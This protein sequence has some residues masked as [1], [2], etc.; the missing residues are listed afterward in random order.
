M[1]K[2]KIPLLLILGIGL[3]NLGNWIYFIAINIKILDLTG[4]AAAVAGLFVI[5]PLAQIITNFWSGSVIDRV[6]VRKLMINIDLVRGALVFVI[7]FISS[8]WLIYTI[9]FMINIVGAFFGPSS[10]IYITKIIDANDRQKFNSI[11]SMTNSGAFL[12]GPAL[13]GLLINFSD[14]DV[15]IFINAISFFVCAIIIFSLPNVKKNPH[16]DKNKVISPKL[17]VEDLQEIRDYMF[18]ARHVIMLYMLF[19]LAM[20]FV[21]SLDSQEAT[22]ITLIMKLSVNDYGNLISI[23]GIGSIIGGG[24]ATIFSKK[25]SYQWFM[26]IGLIFT[27]LFYFTFYSSSQFV[28][29]A[30]SFFLLGFFMSFASS[31]YATFYQHHIPVS[32]MGRFSSLSDLILG[33]IQILFTILLGIFSEIFELQM[34][35]LSFSAFSFILGSAL[36]IQFK[37]SKSYLSVN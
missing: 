20:V 8:V 37:R 15:S 26:S 3:S 1:K 16:E 36:F 7:P 10:S 23:T 12:L 32:I 19:Q 2:W 14:T 9:V 5:K 22:Y 35:C 11:M 4:S 34:A 29:A 27:T 31:G 33:L 13:S 30:L 21:Y 28:I 17:I 24:I 25:M 6:N 18:N